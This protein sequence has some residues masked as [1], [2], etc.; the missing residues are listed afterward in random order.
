MFPAIRCQTLEVFVL[1]PSWLTVAYIPMASY[2]H[3]H[4]HLHF[5]FSTPHKTASSGRAVK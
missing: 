5:F 3:R 1:P 2:F 4:L